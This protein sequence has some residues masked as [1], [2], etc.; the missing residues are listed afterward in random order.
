MTGSFPEIREAA[1]A[2]PPADT[3]LNGELVMW[4]SGQL[5]FER[6]QQ[7]LARRRAGAVEA[8]RQW[9]AQYVVCDLVHAGG[10]VVGWPCQRRRAALESLFADHGS[11][12]IADAVPV[13]TNPVTARGWLDWTAAGLAGLCFKRLDEP[14]PGRSI[15]AEVQGAGHHR[16]GG[17]CR[18]RFPHGAPDGAAGPLR[19]SGPPA[20][21][22]A[23]PHCPRPLA[24]PWPIYWSRRQV[25]IRG[26]GTFS[27]GWPTQRA[28][29]AQM[30]LFGDNGTA[31]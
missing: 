6:L 26:R 18:H 9:P 8:A 15:V 19:R 12:G 5:A 24:A 7:R 25:R 16:S 2:Q 31:V 23:P 30:P 1:L 28:L 29:V 13:P 4:E 3:G 27:A 11:R 17:R 21:H 20:V 10:D 14:R 22:R